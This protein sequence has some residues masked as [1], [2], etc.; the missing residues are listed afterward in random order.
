MCFRRVPE[1]D[2]QR[3]PLERVL[4]D[5]SLNAFAAAMNQSNVTEPGLVCRIDVFL[6]DGLDVA[7]SKGV[8]VEAIFDRD[9]VG[10]RC[11]FL[12]PEGGS[13]AIFGAG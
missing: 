3:M 8:K 1:F 10:H 2:D 12:P 6:D 5:S 4:H 11:N 13:Y 9:P 7:R